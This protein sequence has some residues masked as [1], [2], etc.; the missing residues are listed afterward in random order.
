MAVSKIDDWGFWLPL[1]E[2]EAWQAVALSLDIDPDGMKG[3]PGY[4]PPSSFP[5]QQVSEEFRKRLTLLIDALHSDPKRFSRM[6]PNCVVPE[7]NRV[8]L[9][10]AALLF[11]SLGRTPIAEGLLTAIETTATDET[12]LDRESDL[13][14]SHIENS[15]AI[16]LTAEVLNDEYSE[17]ALTSGPGSPAASSGPIPAQRWQED[18]ILRAIK[19]LGHS[20][21]AL[22]KNVPGDKGVR[23]QVRTQCAADNP[24]KW[25]G[26]SVFKHAWDRLSEQSR[27]KYSE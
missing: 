14:D 10:Q 9:K 17:E 2:V 7:Q 18:E 15:N 21:M 27:I 12:D 4:F 11:K 13:V 22:P 16:E 20:A 1:S 3:A 23:F 26:S 25:I 5:N 24:S 8:R 19:V 6:I